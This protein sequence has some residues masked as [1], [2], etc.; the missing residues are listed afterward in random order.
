MWYINCL[1]IAI[2]FFLLVFA[3]GKSDYYALFTVFSKNCSINKKW[4]FEAQQFTDSNKTFVCKSENNKIQTKMI[5]KILKSTFFTNTIA[6]KPGKKKRKEATKTLKI[7][8]LLC[9]CESWPYSTYF[10]YK[11]SLFQSFRI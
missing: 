1:C 10:F 6:W 3:I 11:I 8:K 9:T 4:S 5:L 7:N 2:D